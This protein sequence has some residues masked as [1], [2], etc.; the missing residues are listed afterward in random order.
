MKVARTPPREIACHSKI[1]SLSLRVFRV[2]AESV[3]TSAS[4]GPQP[5]CGAGCRAPATGDSAPCG[6]R[7]SAVSP[8]S[9]TVAMATGPGFAVEHGMRRARRPS[10]S[11]DLLRNVGALKAPVG[12]R[13]G[14]VRR[15]SGLPV[16]KGQ[17][18]SSPRIILNPVPSRMARGV[19]GF[20][21]P[22]ERGREPSPAAERFPPNF[23]SFPNMS[24]ARQAHSRLLRAGWSLRRRRQREFHG[25]QDDYRRLPPGRDPG[26]GAQR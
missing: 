9:S 17:M 20:T 21:S 3:S 15:V 8:P 7:L 24:A 10:G 19:R 5:Q 2:G 11:C 26:G 23:P 6:R 12:R 16:S 18:P 14:S 22:T 13:R 25:Q 1:R 4:A